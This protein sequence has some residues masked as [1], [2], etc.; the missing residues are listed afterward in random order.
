MV[1][2]LLYSSLEK[3]F[4][5]FQDIPHRAIISA[6]KRTVGWNLKYEHAE[7]WNELLI[8]LNKTEPA[9]GLHESQFW[10]RLSLYSIITII[11]RINQVVYCKH[12]VITQELALPKFLLYKESLVN[13]RWNCPCMQSQNKQ[14]VHRKAISVKP[15][16]AIDVIH[17]HPLSGMG[18]GSS[19]LYYY[20]INHFRKEPRANRYTDSCCFTTYIR[21][22]LVENFR[23]RDLCW[24][25]WV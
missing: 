21:H 3:Q 7:Y 16:Y 8:Y 4:K 2:F 17:K 11:T 19:H 22:F 15:G 1:Y 9:Q 23:F 12:N 13:Q 20:L 6:T 25:P 24:K 14:A 10:L 18:S 5:Q